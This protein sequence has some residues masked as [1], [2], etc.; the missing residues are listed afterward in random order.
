MIFFIWISWAIAFF[1]VLLFPFLFSEVMIEGLA[2]LHLDPRT[3]FWIVLMVLLGGFVNIPIARIPREDRLLVYQLPGFGPFEFRPRIK[4]IKAETIVAVNVGG[5][6][7]P[8][9]LAIYQIFHLANSF[10]SML[11]PVGISS[12]ISIVACNILARPEPGVGIVIPGLLPAV[13]STI[14]ALV[15]APGHA[16]PVAFIAGVVGPLVGADLFNLTDVSKFGP[17]LVSI[18]GAGTFDGIILS[19]ITAAY[20][21]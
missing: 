10:P 21:A 12:A 8:T 11:L 19:G 2:K 20:L 7:V 18:G 17:G 14:C 15:F 5:C 6:L 4:R 3:G 16:P 9:G 13:V 1:L